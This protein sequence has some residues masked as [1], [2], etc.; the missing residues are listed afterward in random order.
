[1]RFGFAHLGFLQQAGDAMERQL[2]SL[3]TTTRDHTIGAQRHVRVMPE[4]LALVDVGNMHFQHWA[5]KRVEGIKDGNRRVGQRA[6]VDDDRSG[7]IAG[8]VDRAND[9]MFRVALHGLEAV[10]QAFGQAGAGFLD[11]SE[12]VMAVNLWLAFAQQIEVWTI[13]QENRLAHNSLHGIGRE[14]CQMA[15]AA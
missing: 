7:L 14:T 5:I 15:V 9:L 11:I 13:D 4:A 8:R 12:G 10:A 3:H 1:M 2:I 6:G